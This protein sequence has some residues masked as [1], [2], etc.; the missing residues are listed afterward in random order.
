[1][2][3]SDTLSILRQEFL[4]IAKVKDVKKGYI[5]AGAFN[6]ALDPDLLSLVSRCWAEH[7]VEQPRIDAIV[8]LPDAGSRLVSMV[9]DMLR[10]KKIL[11][12][13]RTPTAPG[14]WESVIKFNNSSF[15]TE[16][17]ELTS[18]IGFIEPG[19]RLLIVDDVV[20]HGTTAIAAIKALQKAG[21]KIVGLAVVFDKVW[22]GGVEKITAETG[23]P[24]FSLIR[25]K[26]LTKQGKLI[27][28]EPS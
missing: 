24:V 21:V 3:T 7:Y 1:M 2:Q 9:A 15:T 26:K 10:I 12:S 5:H 14:S 19:M 17:E 6:L 25:I 23:V 11:P 16:Q 8:G 18:Q 13:K 22:Q 27:L 28:A 20:A 4:S